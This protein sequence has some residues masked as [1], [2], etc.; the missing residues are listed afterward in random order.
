MTVNKI[1]ENLDP[2]LQKAI[3]NNLSQERRVSSEEAANEEVDELVPVIAKVADIEKFSEM[4]GVHNVNNITMAPDKSGR[5]VTADIAI[6]KLPKVYE[7][8]VVLS[9]EGAQRLRPL[10]KDTTREI[11]IPDLLGTDTNGGEGVIVGIID[12]GCD[13]VHENFRHEDG[14]SRL[15][16]LRDQSRNKSYDKEDINKAL[17]TND[18]YKTLGYKVGLEEH[19]THVMDIA[20]GNG[21][22]TNVKGV[23][24][25]A[26]L[27]FVDPAYWD[28][29]ELHDFGDSRNLMDAISFVFEQAKDHPCVINISLG[30][31]G[32]PHDGT[33]LVEV[34]IDGLVTEKPNR[35]VV[36]A[37][38]NSYDDNIHASGSV[39]GGSHYDLHWE[40]HETDTTTN[41]LEIW[42][43]EKDEFRIEIINPDGQS[44]G[45]VGLEDDPVNTHQ[46]YAVQVK[47]QN[48]GDN[49]AM[50]FCSN[51]SIGIWTIRIHGVRVINGK[52]HAWIERD[53]N[54]RDPRD[55]RIIIHRKQSTFS[56]P[57]D[58]SYTIG[59][60]CTGHKSIVVGSYDA[61][62]S[63]T[64]ISFFSSAGPTR[65]GRQKPEISAPGHGVLAAG[66]RN[67]ATDC[68]ETVEKSG[69]SMAAP[70]VTGVIA[71]MLAE[72]KANNLK[73]KIDQIRE[74]L[75]QTA[76]K[77][78]SI[79]AWDSRYG[80][81]RVDAQAAVNAVNKMAESISEESAV[82]SF[83]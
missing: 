11:K 9:L 40:I 55:P 83:V 2:R 54:I 45:K 29:D 37:A 28:V 76:R 34:G 3:A 42:Y 64:P 72:A 63:G 4:S 14:T 27:I 20:A 69:T 75:K 77:N 21:L 81:G 31:N 25:N 49:H 8:S 56:P 67:C 44:V 33:K 32:G 35:A 80:Y 43:D 47:N 39:A 65:D 26:D 12:H 57:N 23:A 58:N 48:N 16:T 13:F 17:L 7:S 82:K 61:K 66:S 24:P 73:L 19:G 22:G 18:P 30:T 1:P 51:L 70:A 59:S 36:I 52:F 6:S 68:T 46:I 41:E 71:L 74:I 15:I 5:I 10:L 53:D 38:S 60:I 79:G 78:A 50:I 62:T